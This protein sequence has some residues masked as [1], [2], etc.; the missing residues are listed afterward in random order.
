MN[1]FY[2][3]DYCPVTVDEP[4][5]LNSTF[6][7]TVHPAGNA[8]HNPLHLPPSEEYADFSP[9]NKLSPPQSISIPSQS[10]VAK[11]EYRFV[12]PELNFDEPEYRFGN[13]ESD[14]DKP[15]Y[16]FDNTELTFEKPAYCFGNRESDFD[17]HEYHF[18]SNEL[19]LD[20]P[21]LDF[22]ESVLAHPPTPPETSTGQALQRG[23][24]WTNMNTILSEFLKTGI[25]NSLIHNKPNEV[26]P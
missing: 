12:N 4:D 11:P 9:S 16:Y 18:G 22:T 13:P 24:C 21:E 15:E 26:T 20:K 19:T 1:T 17:K 10:H 5:K 6:N 23:N 14:F 3:Y 2:K 7:L 8:K 25:I